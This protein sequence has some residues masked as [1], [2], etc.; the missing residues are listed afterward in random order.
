MD[1]I[2]LLQENI[3]VKVIP[4]LGFKVASIV[5][6]GN[7]MLF[8]PTEGRYRK[9]PYGSDFK[10]SDTSGMDEMMPTIEKC[11][12]GCRSLPDHGD[13]WSV[14]WDVDICNGHIE[15][16]VKL[17]SLPLRF[18]KAV[19]INNDDSIQ[20]DYWVQNLSGERVPFLWALHGLNVIGKGT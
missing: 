9:V 7:E 10:T 2:S 5:Y 6:K 4:E 17:R 1:C 16:N 12:L 20:M 13:V 18:S 15:G 11:V 8:Q 19:K 14:P 3:K